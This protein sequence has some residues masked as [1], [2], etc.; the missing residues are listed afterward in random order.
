MDE[1]FIAMAGVPIPPEAER[2]KFKDPILGVLEW[3]E[4]W[5]FWEGTP[6][7]RDG[8]QIILRI[9]G[10]CDLPAQES[11]LAF[12][13]TLF[14]QLQADDAR[15]RAKASQY[16]LD[17]YNTGWRF[18]DDEEIDA[19]TFESRL[20]LQG[21]SASIGSPGANLGYDADD[22]FTEHQVV[23]SVDSSGNPMYA[24]ME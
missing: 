12:L 22:M 8:R 24:I 10:S 2:P 18:D 9:A 4:K 17:T 7:F 5:E 13:R 21:I 23:V 11:Q 19:A 16:L 6:E 14:Q 20:T 1:G 3:Y 15:F